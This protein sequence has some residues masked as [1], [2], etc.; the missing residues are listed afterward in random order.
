[1]LNTSLNSQ[2]F[3]ASKPTSYSISLKS[4]DNIEKQVVNHS[5]LFS[6]AITPV[7]EVQTISIPS[8]ARQY[9]LC[10][11]SSCT[12]PLPVQNANVD[13]IS[14]EINEKF[15]CSST[16]TTITGAAND[17]LTLQITFPEEF[18]DIPLLEVKTIPD[19]LNKPQVN[20]TVKGIIGFRDNIRPSYGGMYSYKTYTL[21][22]TESEIRSAYLN[23]GSSWCPSK[24]INPSFKY[25]VLDDFET[26][27]RKEVTTETV[28]FC[29]RQCVENLFT[30]QFDKVVSVNSDPY[31]SSETKLIGDE[32]QITVQKSAIGELVLCPIPGDMSATTHSFPQVRLYVDNVPALCE[33]S[34]DHQLTELASPIVDSATV[35]VSDNKLLLILNGNSFTADSPEMYEL[36]LM[37]DG[38]IILKQKPFHSTTTQLYFFN[39]PLKDIPIGSFTGRLRLNEKGFTNSPFTVSLGN[40]G[41]GIVDIMQTGVFKEGKELIRIVG[42]RFLLNYS[43]VFLDDTACEIENMTSSEVLCL[44]PLTEISGNKL[45]KILQPNHI[46][47][48]MEDFTAS[49]ANAPVITSVE[50]QQSASVSG[51]TWIIING[52]RFAPDMLIFIG[53]VKVENFTFVNA[54]QIL[55]LAPPQKVNGEKSIVLFD[56]TN[57]LINSGFSVTYRFEISGIQPQIGSFMGGQILNIDGEG[58]DDNTKVFMKPISSENQLC[59]NRPASKCEIISM[60]SKRIKCKTGSLV[61]THYVTD[62]GVSQE[63]G[64]GYEWEPKTLTIIQGIA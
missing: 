22:S 16:K 4:N 8:S 63:R 43:K 52:L 36:F 35:Q 41:S 30:Y 20:E 44:F 28:A 49:Q 9:K 40:E 31:V 56:S 14:A 33:S 42:S 62:C 64:V 21:N 57:A 32:P 24:L 39:Q 55:V 1:M 5:A 10:L 59:Y 58:F 53:G 23:L 48:K 37:V 25:A 50:Q 60:D 47:S 27:T 51:T 26:S 19:T 45:V 29:G 11:F 17:Y 7:A 46:M 15:N 54:T 61:K 34:C 12:V 13:L 3:K 18:G 2:Q 38:L 6:A